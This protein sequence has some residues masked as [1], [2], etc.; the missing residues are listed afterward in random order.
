LIAIGVF[1]ALF[2]MKPVE[3]DDVYWIIQFGTI[4]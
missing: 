2:F 4:S 1:K 3:F